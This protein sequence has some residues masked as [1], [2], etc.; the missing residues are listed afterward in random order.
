MN[1][2]LD[3]FVPCLQV[4][5]KDQEIYDRKTKIPALSAL[6]DLA[7]NCCEEFNKKYL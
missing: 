4:I 6:G 7:M 3:D 5:L 1:A 2:Y